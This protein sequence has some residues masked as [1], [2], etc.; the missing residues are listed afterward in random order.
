MAAMDE[1]IIVRL[2]GSLLRTTTLGI[3]VPLAKSDSRY[4]STM[5]L[6]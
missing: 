4:S 1:R 5:E 2:T 3:G 6:Q